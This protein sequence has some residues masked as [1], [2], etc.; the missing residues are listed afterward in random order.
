MLF[1]F[2]SCDRKVPFKTFYENGQLKE[3]GYFTNGIQNGLWKYYYENGQLQSEGYWKNN[4]YDSRKLQW[5]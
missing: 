5:K 1:V 4:K 2:F 3:E